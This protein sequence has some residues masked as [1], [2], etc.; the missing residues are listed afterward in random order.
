MGPGIGDIDLDGHLDIFKTH[1]ADDTSILD[2]NDGEGFF[3][4]LTIASGPAVETRFVGWG[5]G[6]MD[7]DND[8]LPD[9]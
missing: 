2:R 3:E 7:P 6:V 1:Y 4:D 5:C 9:L 8:G